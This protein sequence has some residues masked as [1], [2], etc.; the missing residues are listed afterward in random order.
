MSR[1]DKRALKIGKCQEIRKTFAIN[2]KSI[3][4]NHL[5]KLH[6]SLGKD[7]ELFSLMGLR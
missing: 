4:K 6:K 1:Q 7:I 5:F 2:A 3:L